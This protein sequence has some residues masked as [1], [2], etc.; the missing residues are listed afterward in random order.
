MDLTKEMELLQKNR[1][2]G[3]PNHHHQVLKLYQDTQQQ[4]ADIVYLTA[5]QTGLSKEPTDW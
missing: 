4:L 5:A 1:A 2:L 3:G